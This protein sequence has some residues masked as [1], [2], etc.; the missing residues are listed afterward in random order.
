M[1]N[2]LLTGHI[3]ATI[4][5]LTNLLLLYLDTNTLSGS[6]PPGLGKL[7]KLQYLR[8]SGNRLSGE[9]PPAIGQL[10]DLIEF[11]AESNELSGPIPTTI[12]GLTSLKRLHLFGNVLSGDIPPSIGNLAQLT[13]LWLHANQLSGPLPVALGSLTQLATLYLADNS[14]TGGVTAAAIGS[15]ALPALLPFGLGLCRNNFDLPPAPAADPELDSVR[16][17]RLPST[18][19]NDTCPEDPRNANNGFC[20]EDTGACS[21]RTDCTDCGTCHADRFSPTCGWEQRLSLKPGWNGTAKMPWVLN[22]NGR[23]PFRVNQTYRLPPP[24]R[25]SCSGSFC[26]LFLWRSALSFLAAKGSI[27]LTD[28][29][30]QV[31]VPNILYCNTLS[32]KGTNI[33]TFMCYNYIAN[34]NRRHQ[35]GQP[36]ARAH[37]STST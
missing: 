28:R 14:L 5:R 7:T 18:A 17:A 29:H 25:S 1:Q 15:A 24:S 16:F 3:P 19:A 13:E 21:P 20:D 36:F 4:T 26:W 10:S 31:S 2:N 12:G 23:W 37:C 32:S 11:L 27:N 9:L 30:V 22:D 8:L 34:L 35:S 33:T 6:I